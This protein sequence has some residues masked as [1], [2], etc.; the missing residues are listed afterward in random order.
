MVNRLY[1]Y[2]AFLVFQLLT[3][4]LQ[5]KSAFISLPWANLLIRNSYTHTH[6]PMAQPSG[7]IRDSC[8]RTLSHQPEGPGNDQF[9]T[10]QFLL[11]ICFHLP[12][13]ALAVFWQ[14]QETTSSRNKNL[15]LQVEDF[16]CFLF[17][18][19]FLKFCHFYLPFL[20]PY[21]KMRIK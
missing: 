18:F 7:A 19:V 17:C 9:T 14:R 12:F 2:H 15:L 8:P 21:L 11:N 1:L 3:A 10:S 16:V 5:H 13:W 20:I 4:L 6:T